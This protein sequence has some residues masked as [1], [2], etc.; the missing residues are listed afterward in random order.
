[1]YE[2][3]RRCPGFLE[4]N[5]REKD[6]RAASQVWQRLMLWIADHYF[7]DAKTEGWFDAILARARSHP[8]MIRTMEY[9]DHC[10]EHWSSRMPEPYPSFENWRREADSYIEVPGK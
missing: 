4:L 2:F 9:A 3:E 6:S 8:R 7:H 1:V 10:D 5:A